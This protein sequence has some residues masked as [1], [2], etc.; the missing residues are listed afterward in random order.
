MAP[1]SRQTKPLRTRSGSASRKQGK[2][3]ARAGVNLTPTSSQPVEYKVRLDPLVRRQMIGWKLPDG[4]LVDV[5]L[6]LNDDLARSP[7]AALIQDRSWFDA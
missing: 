2:E 6:R 4:L 1:I 5:H 7:T 3:W